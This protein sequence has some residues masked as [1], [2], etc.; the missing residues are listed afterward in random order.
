MKKLI[1]N[2]STIK[3]LRLKSGLKTGSAASQDIS[4]A[5]PP[6]SPSVQAPNTPKCGGA[7]ETLAGG[8]S[9]AVGG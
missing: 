3:A 9:G 1:L 6:P 8:V 5:P 4:C 7:G 2:R